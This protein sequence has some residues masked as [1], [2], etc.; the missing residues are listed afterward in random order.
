MITATGQKETTNIAEGAVHY[1]KN[2]FAQISDTTDFSA[3]N[4]IESCITE[5][6]NNKLS[7]VPTVQEVTESMLFIDPDSSPGPDGISG[8]FYQ[9]CWDINSTEVHNAVK[10]F[11]RGSAPTMFYT[12]TCIIMIP[13]IDHPQK[14]SDLRLISLCNVSSKI[15][16]KILNSR[17]VNLL[18][19]IISKKPK[20]FHKGKSYL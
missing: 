3:L 4:C 10:V 11:F 13:K 2:L 14:I 1:Y 6:E 19:K 12:R 18:P 20:W 9:K 15:I 5:E 8:M 16:S 17:L 7:F